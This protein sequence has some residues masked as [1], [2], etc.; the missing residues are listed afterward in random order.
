MNPK[1]RAEKIKQVA[2][3]LG[4]DVSEVVNS[5]NLSQL[6][7]EESDGAGV[8]ATVQTGPNPN[9]GGS[10]TMRRLEEHGLI[11]N[12]SGDN[13]YSSKSFSAT[14]KQ[15]DDSE[16]PGSRTIQ[17]DIADENAT[18]GY[19]PPPL[20]L[21]S[22]AE[23]TDINGTHYAC[24]TLKAR[25][26]AGQGW[27]FTPDKFG[28][29]KSDDRVP[30]GMVEY[31]RD[32]N[33]HMEFD[34]V[35]ETILMDYYASGNAWL[36]IERNAKGEIVNIYYLPAAHMRV[37]SKEMQKQ[38]GGYAVQVMGQDKSYFR[39][40]M[41]KEE[42][43][44]NF[45]PK[46]YQGQIMNEVVHIKNHSPSSYY[47]GM[48]DI[49]P[50][51]PNITG[52][53]LAR[54]NTIEFFESKGVPPYA[55]FIRGADFE[56]SDA[57]STAQRF[58]N[59][60]IKKQNS[61][62]MIMTFEPG[63]EEVKL[64]ELETE[65]NPD[66]FNEYLEQNRNEIARAH[67]VPPRLISISNGGNMGGSSEGQSQM[68]QFITFVVDPAQRRFEEKIHKH[69][70]SRSN[71]S[72][73]NSDW[74][75]KLKQPTIKS[76]ND[77]AER[78]TKLQE[79]GIYSINEARQ[80]LGED[81]IDRPSANEYVYLFAGEPMGVEDTITSDGEG[82]KKSGNMKVAATI[83]VDELAERDEKERLEFVQNEIDENVDLSKE[84]DSDER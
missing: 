15:E 71:R 72:E 55:M 32:L 59:E 30:K 56:N 17:D 33:P 36:E 16:S 67:H 60:N 75:L 61:Q 44:G 54:E 74:R 81:P 3:D 27:R 24:T 43:D 4:I 42:L 11:S 70:I 63:V 50:V 52:S 26:I 29:V 21:E 76:L 62:I 1:E 84:D 10:S 37:L 58:F 45:T 40:P 78:V 46:R 79:N 65:I 28:D 35:I 7:K 23:L 41:S 34:E 57:K 69:L 48:P 68:E 83:P 5:D 2:D 51:L 39:A 13:G 77:V 20:D 66:V 22:V 31:F 12:E 14:K 8:S 9:Q 82:S 19:I 25:S 80:E 18:K 47:Y 53:H 6:I 64:E 49:T 73:V 38:T